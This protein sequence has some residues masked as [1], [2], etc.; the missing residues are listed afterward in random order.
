M[1]KKR[2]KITQGEAF[3]IAFFH[4]GLPII[5]GEKYEIT[6]KDV[7]TFTIKRKNRKP[8][9][10]KTFP[11][12]IDKEDTDNFFVHLTAEDT[13]TLPCL[14]YRMQL[15]INLEGLGDEVY[16]LVNKELEVVAK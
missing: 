4:V 7:L 13:E 16:T 1:R 15:T 12:E 11:G 3:S 9:L 8:V 10:V 14:C 5:E 2:Y 6:E